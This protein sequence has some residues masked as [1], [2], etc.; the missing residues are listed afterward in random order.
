MRDRS[1][2]FVVLLLFLVIS[3]RLQWASSND[4]VEEQWK[5]WV[6]CGQRL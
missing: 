5:M 4:L 3:S 6:V 1:L 2:G